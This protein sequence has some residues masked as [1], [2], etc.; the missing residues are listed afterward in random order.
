MIEEILLILKEWADVSFLG[1]HP[2]FTII[3][4]WL[5]CLTQEIFPQD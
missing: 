3:P 4:I 2:N 1:D 5:W